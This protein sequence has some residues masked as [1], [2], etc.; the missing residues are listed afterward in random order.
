MRYP[1]TKTFGPRRMLERPVGTLDCK[2]R[3]TT[4]KRVESES[5][6]S[7]TDDDGARLAL[8]LEL[9]RSRAHPVTETRRNLERRTERAERALH[10]S[11]FSRPPRRPWYGRREMRAQLTGLYLMRSAGTPAVATSSRTASIAGCPIVATRSKN[12]GPRNAKSSSR[13]F[14]NLS[15]SPTSSTSSSQRTTNTSARSSSDSAATESKPIDFAASSDKSSSV[16]STCVCARDR[17]RRRRAKL[18]VQPSVACGTERRAESASVEAPRAAPTGSP[19]LAAHFR[20]IAGYVSRASCKRC[21]S[22]LPPVKPTSVSSR[23]VSASADVAR[24]RGPRP[25]LAVESQSRRRKPS[26]TPGEWVLGRTTRR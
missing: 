23:K 19:T 8:S 25:C 20:W 5:Q 16:S 17:R 24:H 14:R 11:H 4:W 6:R 2:L 7:P 18:I 9:A 12:S 15:G 22:H 1:R 13:V 10:P 26:G 21:S 3:V